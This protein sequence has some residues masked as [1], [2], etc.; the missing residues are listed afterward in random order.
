MYSLGLI[1]T[2]LSTFALGKNEIKDRVKTACKSGNFSA[3]KSIPCADIKQG[4]L[5]KC[6][7]NKDFNKDAALADLIA[8]CP[9]ALPEKKKKFEKTARHLYKFT[10][11]Q[12]LRVYLADGRCKRL[13]KKFRNFVIGDKELNV[14][15]ICQQSAA[16]AGIIPGV[17]RPVQTP[18]PKQDGTPAP[19]A[20]AAAQNSTAPAAPVTPVEGSVKDWDEARVAENK[21]LLASLNSEQ[22]AELGQCNNAC[23]GLTAEHFA[24]AGVKPEVVASLSVR[25]F[26]NIPPAA[27]AGLTKD[28]VKICTIWPF[29]RRSQ[30]K[31]IRP[32][33]IVALP[34]DQLG[35]GKQD[36][37]RP[38]GHACFGITKDQLKA[39]KKDKKAWGRYKQRCVKNA[40]IPQAGS[41][42]ANIIMATLLAMAL[43]L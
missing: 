4:W 43:V 10:Q 23:L 21:A 19:A 18:A 17:G 41:S 2:L 38:E 30:L 5:D 29:I 8:Y 31:A 3:I 1:V 39:I 7:N 26:R 24:H 25:C 22:A 12:A 35:I 15:T 34:F 28:Q 6:L 36:K 32:E 14:A 33:V 27:F 20:G 9:S 16:P 40:A 11:M 42:S 13:G 37:K